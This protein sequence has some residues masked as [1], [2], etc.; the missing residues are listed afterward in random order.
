MP[1]TALSSPD[2]ISIVF[3]NANL[4]T[5]KTVPEVTVPPAAVSALVDN[6]L[7]VAS[8]LNPFGSVALIELPST[9]PVETLDKA[10]TKG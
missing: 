2:S 3:D 6:A 9:T 10:R 1:A 5:A 8:V 4:P 7:R